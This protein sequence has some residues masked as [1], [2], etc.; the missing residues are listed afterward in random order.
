M[1]VNAGHVE[2]TDP[3]AA[4]N[5]GFNTTGPGWVGKTVGLG[6]IEDEVTLVIF[7]CE[8]HSV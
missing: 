5:E 2:V 8:N 1:E 6:V 3:E 7:L 4:E